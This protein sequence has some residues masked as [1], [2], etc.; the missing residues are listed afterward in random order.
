MIYVSNL[1]TDPDFCEPFIVRK[2]PGRWED[3]EF[4]TLPVDKRVTGIVEPTTGDDLEQIPEGDRVS[5]MVT[6][7]TKEAIDLSLDNHLADEFIWRKKL[8]KAVTV[9]DWS[10]HGFYKTIASL[11]EMIDN[12]PID[13]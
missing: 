1:I 10:R 11:V 8:Y 9:L 13:A 3:G 2:K 4:V 6:F 7:Y 5:G 12:E